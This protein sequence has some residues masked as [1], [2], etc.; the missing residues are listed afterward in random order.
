METT[1]L[2]RYEPPIA[3]F[4]RI[5]EEWKQ[6]SGGIE[7]TADVGSI[8]S[9]RNGNDVIENADIYITGVQSNL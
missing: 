9:M 7:Y 6:E 1:S 3:S 4:N 8:E 2:H 5:Y